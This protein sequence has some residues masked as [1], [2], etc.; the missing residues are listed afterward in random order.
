MM[1]LTPEQMDQVKETGWLREVA[2]KTTPD[3][4]KVGCAAASLGLRGGMDTYGLLWL[5]AMRRTLVAAQPRTA[6]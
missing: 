3:V 5:L 4:T 2:F 1:K 6:S